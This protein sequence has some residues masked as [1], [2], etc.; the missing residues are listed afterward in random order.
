MPNG[1]PG[2]DWFTDVVAHSLPT[3][4]DEADGLISQIAELSTESR[5]KELVSL[6]DGS[7]AEVG[8]DELASRGSKV[9]MEYRNLRPN[10]LRDLEQQLRELRDRLSDAPR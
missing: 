3:F 7:L 8:Y 1:K 6:V 2:D 4:S 5:P 9:G 10:E